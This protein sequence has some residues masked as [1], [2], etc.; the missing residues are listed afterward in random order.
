[1]FLVILRISLSET[2]PQVQATVGDACAPLNAILA[3]YMY[4]ILHGDPTCLN[5]HSQVHEPAFGLVLAGFTVYVACAMTVIILGFMRAQ[6]E[7]R[8]EK[9]IFLNE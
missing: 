8:L 3:E 2:Q 6:R 5:V 1:M 9:G 7:R 4:D